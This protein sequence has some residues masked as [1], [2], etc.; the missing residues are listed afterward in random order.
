[1][2]RLPVL[3]LPLLG[4]SLL[5]GCPT[6]GDDDDAVGPDL[7]ALAAVRADRLTQ[8][9]AGEFNSEAQS[10]SDPNYWDIQVLGCAVLAPELGQ[11]VLYIE[12]AFMDD[13]AAPYRQR[14]YVVEASSEDEVSAWTTVYALTDA[15]AAIG[16]CDQTTRP[17]F[18]EEDVELRD[19]CGVQVTWSSTEQEFS[20]GTVEDECAS[21]INDATYATSDVVIGPT[22][23][24]SWDRGFDGNDEQVWGAVDGP[25]V[26]DRR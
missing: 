10:L 4:L 12:Q 5:A 23:F 25:Y 8:W 15:N 11:R 9:L 14:I 1:M 6:T 13:L 16:L 26:F 19:G 17:E 7:D 18:S 24:T 2:S 3:C 22:G 20:G 21:T